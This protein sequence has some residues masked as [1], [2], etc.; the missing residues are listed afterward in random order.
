M[1]Y[2]LINLLYIPS[3]LVA[4]LL[5]ILVFFSWN[6]GKKMEIP[7]G[8]ENGIFSAVDSC[9][10]K[11]GIL[12]INGWA[13]APE[14]EGYSIHLYLTNKD[15]LSKLIP[16]KTVPRSDSFSKSGAKKIRFYLMSGFTA[17]HVMDAREN[18]IKISIVI[19]ARNGKTY[20]KDYD[21]IN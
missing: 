11:N 4:S 12:T 5:C 19:P 14:T 10:M 7:R 13:T 15:G 18:G 9:S 3:L 2:K 8:Q 17:S 6:T 20:R 1:N 21:C 16:I